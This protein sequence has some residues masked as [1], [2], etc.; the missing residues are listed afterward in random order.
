MRWP[1]AL[2][3]NI[4]ERQLT[5]KENHPSLSWSNEDGIVGM[6]GSGIRPYMELE[7]STV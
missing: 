1:T 3:H 5:N 7:Y 6:V 2:S 4:P